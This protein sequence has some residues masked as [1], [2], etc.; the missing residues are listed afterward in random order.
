MYNL[1]KYLI[2]AVILSLALQGGIAVAREVSE[3]E[4]EAIEQAESVTLE[5]LEI[6]DPGLLPTSPF[7]F[8]KEWGRGMQSFFTFN[9]IAKAEL[10]VKFSNEKAAELKKVEEENPN[11]EQAIDRALLNFQRGQE[12]VAMRL[13]RLQETSENPNVDRLLEKIAEK[14][15][16]HDKL[17]QEIE[18]RHEDKVK[19]RVRLK[20]ATLTIANVIGKAAEKDNPEKFVQRLKKTLEKTR[21]SVLKDV[22]A[23]EIL[24]RIGENIPEEVRMRLEVVRDGFKEKARLRIEELAEEGEDRV[25]A[26]LERIPGDS[27]RRAVV[28]NEI[29]LRI[30]DRGASALKKAQDAVEKKI[31]DAPDRN[32]KTTEQIRRAIKMIERAQQKIEETDT[33]REGVKTL[34]EQA[35]RHLASAKE[36]FE[37]EKYGEAFGQ[38]RAAEVAARNV[39]K[40]LEEGIERGPD[41]IILQRVQERVQDRV[42][43]P[44]PTRSVR[45]GENVVCTEEYRPVC[46]VD[47]KTYFNRCNAEKQNRV[48]VAHEGEC[49]ARE[50]GEEDDDTTVRFEIRP[51][52]ILQ[53]I[54]PQRLNPIDQSKATE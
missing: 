40:A 14:S 43:L 32:E 13:E 38:A 44:E 48:K 49:G 29:R 31:S 41:P 46:G 3:A 9:A 39:L 53:K 23:V 18:K 1:T 2:A 45:E 20:D 36:A 16:L 47:G 37:Q 30:S 15:V 35:E 6:E 4:F 21:G 19:I 17:L 12:K 54:A 27:G 22:R 34:L 28:L 33:V 10:E 7:Y 11:N 24:D 26:I 8:F 50:R 25:R 51:L 42:R 52:D 5:D